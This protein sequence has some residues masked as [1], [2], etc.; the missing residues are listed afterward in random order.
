MEP[1]GCVDDWK[2]F[3][4][5]CTADGSNNRVWTIRKKYGTDNE[6]LLISC[7]G[8]LMTQ[9]NIDRYKL[10][11]C[12]SWRRAAESF[13]FMQGDNQGDSGS[14]FKLPPGKNSTLVKRSQHYFH[15]CT[16]AII[17]L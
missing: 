14:F 12:N 8:N 9:I 10:D 3:D 11:K 4:N 17:L 7:N 2:N 16:L 15:N 1:D 6:N 5:S 13:T